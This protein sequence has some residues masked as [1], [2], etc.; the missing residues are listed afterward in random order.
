MVAQ[1]LAAGIATEMILTAIRAAEDTATNAVKKAKGRG[2]RLSPDW[3]PSGKDI[4]FA[5]VS[6]GI[7]QVNKELER[8]RDYWAAQ[9]GTAGVKSDWAATW[10]NWIRRAAERQTQH[11]RTFNGTQRFPLG[12]G[13]A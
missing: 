1:M 10:R 7:T 11:P 8:F 2:T 5:A 4:E 13:Y 9:P 6:I 12:G 3:Q